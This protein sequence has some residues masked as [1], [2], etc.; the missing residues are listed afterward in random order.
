MDH[1]LLKA[2]QA[3]VTSAEW[4]KW[5]HLTKGAQRAPSTIDL[6]QCNALIVT[7][8]YLLQQSTGVIVAGPAL[9]GRCIRCVLSVHCHLLLLHWWW[10]L[11]DSTLLLSDHWSLCN[12]KHSCG[13]TKH[14][15]TTALY[16]KYAEIVFT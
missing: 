4:V 16:V 12:G 10:T 9:L 5:S 15:F 7:S 6:T 8:F 1:G 13:M 3:K 11:C 14:Q 2:A